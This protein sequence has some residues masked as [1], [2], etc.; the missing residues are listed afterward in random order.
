MACSNA[1]GKGIHFSLSLLSGPPQYWPLRVVSSAHSFY[2]ETVTY[3]TF[4][5][6]P[7]PTLLHSLQYLETTALALRPYGSQVL[8]YLAAAVSDFFIPWKDLVR[9]AGLPCNVVGA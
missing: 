7:G 3:C 5:S 9:A 1:T 6:L 4:K 8:F 2:T